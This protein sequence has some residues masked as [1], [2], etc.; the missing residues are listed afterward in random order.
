MA[1]AMAPPASP[2][3]PE[4]DRCGSDEESRGAEAEE[5]EGG[6]ESSPAAGTGAALAANHRLIKLSLGRIKTLMKTD[7]DV[8]LTSQE[9]VLVIAKATVGGCDHAGL[10]Q[11]TAGLRRIL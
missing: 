11:A 4:A 1:A 3:E 10:L 9:S 5:E 2:A 7:P 6:P 8:N